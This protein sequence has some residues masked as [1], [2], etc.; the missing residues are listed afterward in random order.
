[1]IPI[2]SISFS[3]VLPTIATS[4][5]M[6]GTFGGVAIGLGHISGTAGGDIATEVTGVVRGL[7]GAFVTSIVGLAV[8][9][10]LTL[11]SSVLRSQ[12]TVALSQLTDALNAVFPVKSHMDLMVDQ[13]AILKGLHHEQAISRQ[14]LQNIETETGESR[15][16]MQTLLTDLG[17]RL[18]NTVS[19]MIL[20]ELSKVTDVVREQV[21]G[22][23]DNALEN[24]RAF[25]E[26]L[27]DQ[28]TGQLHGTFDLLSATLASFSTE[29]G[30]ATTQL[31]VLF[32]RLEVSLSGQSNLIEAQAKGTADAQELMQAAAQL[33]DLL[34]QIEAARLVSEQSN[35]ESAKQRVVAGEQVGATLTNLNKAAAVFDQS[36]SRLQEASVHV[37]RQVEGLANAVTAAV[38]ASQTAGEGFSSAATTLKSRVEQE[39]TLLTSMADTSRSFKQALQTGG[40]AIEQF[41]EAAGSLGEQIITLGEIAVQTRETSRNMADSSTVLRDELL[42]SVTALQSASVSIGA[43]ASGTTDWADRAT[44]AIETFG[45]QWQDVLDRSLSTMDTSLAN[46]VR[47][48][49]GLM[50]DLEDIVDDMVNKRSS[51]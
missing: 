8:A 42:K 47:A 5:G 24:A 27:T 44:S 10:V 15:G 37:G 32:K 48:I 49:G 17:D 20:P 16:H 7:S 9:V 11:A 14:H 36:A 22:A 41:K 51:R 43:A 39:T 18:E 46:S 3:R 26:E 34:S 28:F 25:S 33:P 1:M 31:D 30:T 45:D 50:K 19:N 23:T 40:P 29:F 12:L 35:A 13:L 21:D 4:I 38:S 6:L 2:V